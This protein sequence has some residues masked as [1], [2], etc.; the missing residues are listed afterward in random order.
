[1]PLFPRRKTSGTLEARADNWGFLLWFIIFAM[2]TLVAAFSGAKFGPG[3]WYDAIA[4]PGWTPPGWAF[5]VV[6][7]ILYL[8]IAIAGTLVFLK[9]GGGTIAMLFWIAQLVVNGLWSF[10]FF[11]LQRIDAAMV[12]VT[13]LALLIVGFIKFAWPHSRKAALL[14]VPYLAWVLTAAA[15]NFHVWALNGFPFGVFTPAGPQ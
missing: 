2:L 14:F 5:P 7:S 1:M 6:W 13:V 12:V 11:G 10:V 15:L 9:R 4:K 8:F 3:E